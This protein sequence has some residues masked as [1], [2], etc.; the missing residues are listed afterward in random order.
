MA[1]QQHKTFKVGDKVRIYGLRHKGSYNGCLGTVIGDF[2]K[3]AG[4]YPVHIKEDNVSI[5]VKP[6]N[7]KISE[8]AEEKKKRQQEARRKYRESEKGKEYE[9][10]SARKMGKQAYRQKQ[11]Q[12]QEQKE[13]MYPQAVVDKT[14]PNFDWNAHNHAIKYGYFDYTNATEWPTDEQIT[15]YRTKDIGVS[16]MSILLMNEQC[17][18]G[19]LKPHH[20]LKLYENAP[21]S[22]HQIHMILITNENVRT[23]LKEHPVWKERMEEAGMTS[24]H[25]IDILWRKI[26]LGDIEL[27]KMDLD[28]H[29]AVLGLLNR[30]K[31][32]T[33]RGDIKGFLEE[34][35]NNI[36]YSECGL[37]E[38]H[39]QRCC[40]ERLKEDD[41]I[42]CF[43]LRSKER[44]CD[45]M[46]ALNQCNIKL[47]DFQQLQYFPADFAWNGH[48]SK[49]TYERLRKTYKDRNKRKQQSVD[50]VPMNT[51]D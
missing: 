1:L 45:Y 23:F 32:D 2:V 40:N 30:T 4:R 25:E 6:T 37:T 35:D 28:D 47:D 50:D 38:C 17:W 46:N 24:D 14:D 13:D 16:M 33:S 18:K 43:F 15:K 21:R 36:F 19:F 41:G 10:S 34:V 8:T 20:M 44:T 27:N 51:E 11:K 12:K 26:F 48:A 29:S 49:E 42:I 22:W 31:D 39:D 9:K 3:T 7:M 5:L